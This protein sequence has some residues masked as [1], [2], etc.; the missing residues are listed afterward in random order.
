MIWNIFCT[1]AYVFLITAHQLQIK[2]KSVLTPIAHSQ[3][4]Q[5]ITLPTPARQQINVIQIAMK[6]TLMWNDTLKQV[7][8]IL[9]AIRLRD[10]PS[11]ESVFMSAEFSIVKNIALIHVYFLDINNPLP[12][13]QLKLN[14]NKKQFFFHFD[15]SQCFQLYQSKTTEIRIL[16]CK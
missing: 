8:T 12:F 14:N 15:T 9:K 4:C 11:F 6:E 5:L 3:A 10:L 2:T 13:I 1:L 16:F 7:R